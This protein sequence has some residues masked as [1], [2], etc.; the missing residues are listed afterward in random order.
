MGPDKT[1]A[2]GS[3]NKRQSMLRRVFARD[4]GVCQRCGVRTVM[5]H[6]VRRGHFGPGW[7]VFELHGV[8]VSP[9]GFLYGI[10]T[11]EHVVPRSRG[12]SD[13][14]SNLLLYCVPCNAEADMAA[15]GFPGASYYEHSPLTVRR[16][17]HRADLTRWA[18]DGGYQPPEDW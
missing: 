1:A 5:I 17:A 11:V 9:G 4:G 14:M 13:G 2:R 7:E 6:A 8:A 12:G 16:R 10:A 18:D 15:K 3:A